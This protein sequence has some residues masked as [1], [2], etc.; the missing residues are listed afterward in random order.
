MKHEAF[1][2]LGSNLNDPVKQVEQAIE[3]IN[4]LPG[5]QVIKRSS[6]Y[7]TEPVGFLDQPHFI[8]AVIKIETELSPQ[9]L[10]KALLQIET[11][12]GR[13]RTIKNGPR[14]LDCDLIL[15]A[16]VTLNSKELTL[17]HPRM[18]ERDF[19]LKPL[20]EIEPEWSRY[21]V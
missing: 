5:T 13:I 16:G 12:Q 19:V 11:N 3:A 20:A 15:Y 7:E 6:L 18:L 21:N 9:I 14:T 2:A 4:K 17:P 1:V 8:N 10:L